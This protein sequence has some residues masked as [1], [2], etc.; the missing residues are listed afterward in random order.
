MTEYA[1]V[2]SGAV[3]EIK[4]I[5]PTLHAQW[6]AA[7]NPKA[8]S[9][10]PIV[11]DP[12][13][14]YDPTIQVVEPY[15]VVESSR[16]RRAWSVRPKTAD[17]LRKVWSPLEFLER[18]TPSELDEIETRRLTDQ[19]VRAFYRAASFAQEVVS[20]DPRTVAGMNYL[21]NIGL[22]TAA[23]KEEILNG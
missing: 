10:L 2:V 11:N 12:N 1:Y 14:I 15:F 4:D 21:V 20:D 3:M 8:Q 19:G 17:E 23:R 6:V 7:G 13:P 16:V 5:S 9:Y 22:L 18:F